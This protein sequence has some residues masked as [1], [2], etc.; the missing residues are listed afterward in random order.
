VTRWLN[1]YVEHR[2][3]ELRI[4]SELGTGWQANWSWAPSRTRWSSPRGGRA[5]VR[6][7]RKSPIRVD[8]AL[9]VRFLP[10]GLALRIARRRLQDADQIA[11]AESDGDQGISDQGLRRTQ[12]ARD[13]LTHLQDSSRPPLLRGTLAIA[14]GAASHE[15]LEQRVELCRRAF[16]N[17]RLHRPL[18]GQLQLFVQHLPGQRT[19]VS[20]YDDTFT[21]EQVGR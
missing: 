18:G 20:G 1:S 13:L 6:S 16:A 10:N 21:T 14:I 3:R 8:L 15:E 5:D 4:E 12:Q 2:G 19:R 9:T 7:G 11:R 17:V